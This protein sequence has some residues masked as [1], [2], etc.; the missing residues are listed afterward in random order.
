VLVEDVLTKRPFAK[1]MITAML[2]KILTEEYDLAKVTKDCLKSLTSEDL[3]Q[4]NRADG[5]MGEYELQF[6]GQR[7]SLYE[8]EMNKV[9][10]RYQQEGKKDFVPQALNS[11]MEAKKQVRFENGSDHVNPSPRVVEDAQI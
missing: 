2:Q 8:A 4:L 6:A 5:L 11:S 3:M 10:K 7:D 9:V 1:H